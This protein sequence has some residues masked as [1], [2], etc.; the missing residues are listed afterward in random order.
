[1][2]ISPGTS[3]ARP[4]CFDSEV[5]AVKY[6]VM[7]TDDQRK[8]FEHRVG[9]DS[10]CSGAPDPI[11]TVGHVGGTYRYRVP[12]GHVRFWLEIFSATPIVTWAGKHELVDSLKR[13]TSITVKTIE[14][15]SPSKQVRVRL[16]QFFRG[17]YQNGP[18]FHQLDCG[19]DCVHV[20]ADQ[21]KAV[22][23]PSGT[24]WESLDIYVVL[25]DDGSKVNVHMIVDGYCATGVGSQPPS[26][27][28]YS[29]MELQYPREIY[30]YTDQLVG[31][32]K[33][34]LEKQG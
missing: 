17:L 5:I 29:S 4:N 21:L 31:Q 15:T 14:S 3:E 16:E 23:I 28:S 18:S 8:D 20:T 12:S 10:L 32:L 27:S 19:D 26:L 22:V 30:Q 7:V 25:S 9:L 33:I 13:E 6:R 34:A 11:Y 2:Q 24:L 1:M